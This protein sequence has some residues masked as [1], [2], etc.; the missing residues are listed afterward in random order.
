[1]LFSIKE[2]IM[3]LI[4][5]LVAL[6]I[7]LSAANIAFAQDPADPFF[8]AL[9]V[10]GAEVP[11][12]LSIAEAK[13]FCADSFPVFYGPGG[14]YGADLCFDGNIVLTSN[15]PITPTPNGQGVGLTVFNPQDFCPEGF[16]F[17]CYF[18]TKDVYDCGP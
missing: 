7:T 16:D 9:A 13:E 3:K 18:K 1:M 2:F 5:L 17:S 6:T 11:Q 14:I 12:E 15:C 10:A 8:T 4:K